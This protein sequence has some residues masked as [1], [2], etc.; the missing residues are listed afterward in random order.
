MDGQFDRAHEALDAVTAA[1]EADGKADPPSDLFL[2]IE[3]VRAMVLLW[4]DDLDLAIERAGHSYEVCLAAENRTLES[5]NASVLAQGLFQMGSYASARDWADR[6]L[7]TGEAIGN[8]G[9]VRS[10]SLLGLAARLELGESIQ[11]GR[12]LEAL[13]QGMGSQVGEFGS[14]FGSGGHLFVE[15]LLEL[16]ELER[17][18]RYADE[19][20]LRSGGR[21]RQMQSLLATA[22]TLRARGP[23]F[24][25]EAEEEY[26]LAAAVA[27]EIGAR[28]PAITAAIGLG[29]IA[30]E[31]GAQ[32]EATEALQKAADAAG[33]AGLHRLRNQALLALAET[34]PE[35]SL[36]G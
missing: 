16:G 12:A 15:L 28:A 18:T 11:A 14:G 1:L 36:A 31:R 35:A 29:A 6:A 8:A 20:A 3:Y 24:Y 30:A 2:S 21:L 23:A 17:A 32:T 9:A 34:Q 4:R 33:S 22:H 5:A 26:R 19:L 13:E 10:G 27:E 7:A 25:A